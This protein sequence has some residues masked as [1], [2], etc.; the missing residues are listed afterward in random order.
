MYAG[1]WDGGGGG[2]GPIRLTGRPED[3]SSQR[4]FVKAGPS[5]K[6]P[7]WMRRLVSQETG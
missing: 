4:Y 3:T 6:A 5:L 1:E 2:G 7:P